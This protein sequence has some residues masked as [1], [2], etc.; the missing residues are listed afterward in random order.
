MQTQYGSCRKTNINQI[1]QSD[2]MYKAEQKKRVQRKLNLLIRRN[3]FER[4]VC[5]NEMQRNKECACYSH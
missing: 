1:T 5:D 3:G 4:Y 2:R